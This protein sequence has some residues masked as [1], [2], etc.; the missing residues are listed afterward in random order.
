MVN[1]LIGWAPSTQVMFAKCRGENCASRQPNRDLLAVCAKV[2]GFSEVN[3]C[4]SRKGGKIAPR[5]KA[6]SHLLHSSCGSQE[7]HIQVKHKKRLKLG[8]VEHA[9]SVSNYSTLLPQ[10][11][12][13]RALGGFGATAECAPQPLFVADALFLSKFATDTP[14]VVHDVLAE[15]EIGDRRELGHA[16]K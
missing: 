10:R 15:I 9:A 2:S 13:A 11:L 16:H 8:D 1:R 3:A 14:G 12:S 4:G 7:A 6:V 5:M